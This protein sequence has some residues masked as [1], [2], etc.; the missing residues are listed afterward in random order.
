MRYNL[1]LT[2]LLAGVLMTGV[3]T[4]AQVVAPYGQTE[5]DFYHRGLA[6]FENGMYNRAS[7]LFEQAGDPL[8]EAYSILCQEMIGSP[9]YESRLKS[10][11]ESYPECAIAPQMMFRHALILFDRQDYTAAAD[12]FDKVRHKKLDKG[13]L[14]EYHYKR[15][16]CNFVAEEYREA[17]NRFNDVL[18][19]PQSEYTAPAQFTMGYVLYLENSFDKA[20]GWF[21][22]SADDPRFADLSEFY[23]IECRFMK[24][25]YEYVVD[26][27]EKLMERIPDERQP[28]LS[29]LLSESYLVLGNKSKALD[30]FRKEAAESRVQTRSDY[31]HAGSVLYSV[32]DFQGAID[33]FTRMT[34]RTDS[35]GQIANYQLGYSYIRKGNK[36]AALDS[37]NDAA[38]YEYDGSIQEDA[39]FN[40]AKLAFDLN[41]D[42]SGFKAY[43]K[44]YSTSVK[45]EQIYNYMALAS[46]IN[47]DYAAAIE[48]YDNID[49]LDE[50]QRGNYVKANYL[51]AGQLMD[52]GSWSDAV[53]YLK[54]AGFY[55]PKTDA[56][57][58]MSRYWL[59]QAYFNSEKYDD[60]LKTLSDLYNTSAL[61][62]KPEGEL[63]PYD[64]AY[65]HLRQENLANASRWFDTYLASGSELVRQDAMVRR[66]DCDFLRRNYNASIEGY[67]KV[68]DAYRD[69]N[70][71]YPYYRQAL[72]YGLSGDRKAKVRV[73]SAVKEASPEAGMYSEAMYELGR[74]C[75]DISDSKGAIEAFNLLRSNSKDSTYVARA[76]IGL[77]MVSRNRSEYDQA[78]E[79]YKAVIEMMPGSEYAQDALLAIESIYQ[80]R[81]QPEMYLAYLEASKL[82]ANK[83]PEEREM[84]YFNTAEQ[85]FLSENWQ[86]AVRMLEDYMSKYP[87]GLKKGE[88][89]FYLAESY[90]A[91]GNKEKACAEYEKVPALISEG[92]FAESSRL[93]AAA[94]NYSLERYPEAYEAYKGLLENAKMESNKVTARAGMLN[95]AFK[96]KNYEAAVEASAAVEGI[97]SEFIRAKSLMALSRRD[98]AMR[99]FRKLAAD[100]SC[101]EGAESAFILIQDMF[102]RAEFEKVENEVYAFSQKGAS[103]SYWLARA[104]LV[105]GDSFAARGNEA[106]ARATYESIRD[107]YAPSGE[108]DDIQDNVK[109]RLE[110]LEN[111]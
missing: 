17:K 87:E 43:L 24:R 97:G 53:P 27:G 79:N 2:I 84:M 22:K 81:K 78:L 80:T 11:L 77:G 66:A 56:L 48:A 46:L 3:N 18:L 57:N 21:T 65:C 74:G 59:A 15:G 19:L 1:S 28:R 39:A 105:L 54:A 16:Y 90:K 38:K 64:I 13:L 96:A 82:N 109:L 10:Y 94:I 60:A 62:G 6:L 89:T 107:G 70:N 104:Y 12:A 49:I 68:L 50:S 52:A 20:L 106:Q 45:G 101:P 23:I 9:E 73:L 108:N 55:Y 30:Y 83:T 58:Q 86:N 92:S 99:L 111:K 95:S 76:L 72:A 51:R 88:A 63:L 36:V 69:T 31:F 47:R 98:E 14:P 41:H 42:D 110:R 5:S 29:R 7:A 103:Q 91:M 8:S 25:D 75:L 32:S 33:N 40:F 93:N 44:K 85:V 4:A 102:D 35:L 67:Q 37:F 100:P 26:K 71:I 34:D 61:Y